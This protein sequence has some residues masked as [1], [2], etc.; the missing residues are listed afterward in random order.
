VA[1]IFCI[2]VG[3]RGTSLS[4]G[5]KARINLARAVYSDADIYLLDDPLSAVDAEVGR[6]LFESCILTTLKDK[7]IIL[8]THQL[9]FLKAADELLLLNGGQV[10]AQGTYTELLKTGI[11][12]AQLLR[13][14]D[15]TTTNPQD[16]P[17]SSSAKIL[18]Y[19]GTG[20]EALTRSKSQPQM[21][22][23]SASSTSILEMGV[24]GNAPVG[25]EEFE[26]E[27][28]PA[29]MRSYGQKFDTS[30]RM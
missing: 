14:E 21:M 29:I 28:E 11:N 19:K 2:K 3:D 22:R 10:S 17:E 23:R 16:M 4:G 30:R 1:N 7:V 27:E 8:V 24:C 12:F 9:Q 20:K 6:H 25:F 26:W 15:T 5:Q 13:S 18:K